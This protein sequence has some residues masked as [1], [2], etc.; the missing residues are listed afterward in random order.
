MLDQEARALLDLMEQAVQAG[1]PRL[2]TLPYKEGRL[3]VDKMSED[4]EAEPLAVGEIDDGAFAGPGGEIG[5]RHYVP[6]PA[7]D[8][9][10]PT[11][12]PHPPRALLTPH[13]PAPH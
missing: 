7:A 6:L 1:R 5:F 10:L 8:G 13:P 2:E 4:S 11:P 9:P 3:A 12:A